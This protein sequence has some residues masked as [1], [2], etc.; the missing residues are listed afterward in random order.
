MKQ[1]PDFK[2]KD[3]NDKYHS[4]NDYRGNWLVVY[5]YPKDDTPG[6]TTEACSFRD[7]LDVIGEFGNASVVGISIDSVASHKKFAEKHN[8]NFTLLSDE[9]HKV[10]EAYGA[11][12]PKKYLGREY[13]GVNRNTY[14][15]DREGRIAKEYIGVNPRKHV[16]EIINDLKNLQS[17]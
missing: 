10:I 7:E 9:D 12:V 2:L 17:K 1:A 6:C 16:A 8:L 15:I 3:Q 11:W 4:L 13:L 14:L 5:F